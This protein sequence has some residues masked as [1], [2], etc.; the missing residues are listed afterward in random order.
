M[1]DRIQLYEIDLDRRKES[2]KTWE[3]CEEEK[4][5]VLLNIQII[6]HNLYDSSNLKKQI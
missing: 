1:K 3:V 6:Y 4:E 2:I 5:K